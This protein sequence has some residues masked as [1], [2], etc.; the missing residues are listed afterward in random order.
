MRYDVSYEDDRE[1]ITL[2][3]KMPFLQTYRR[4]WSWSWSWRSYWQSNGYNRLNLNFWN[5]EWETASYAGDLV[6]RER[7]K[8]CSWI[9][10]ETLFSQEVTKRERFIKRLLP[11]TKVTNT[12]FCDTRLT[13]CCI[14]WVTILTTDVHLG[15]QLGLAKPS[16]AS[17]M[18]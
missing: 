3:Y 8:F 13:I 1:K 4:C 16:N 7:G 6:E 10:S 17:Y 18:N 9:H 11:I 14:S 2:P 12:A 15:L 5:F